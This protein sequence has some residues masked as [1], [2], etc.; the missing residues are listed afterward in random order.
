MAKK[1]GPYVGVTG[2]MSHFEVSEAL[3]MVPQGSARRL[4][5]GVLMSSKTLAGQQNKWPGRY[6]RKEAVADIFVDDPRVLNLIHYSTN[7]PETLSSQLME[8]TELAGPHCDGFQ[9][10]ITWP[11]ISEIKAYWEA[12]PEKFL[13][14]QLKCRA[15]TQVKSMER[16]AELVGA[17][18]PMINAVLIDFR[19][20]RTASK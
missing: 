15:I 4:M 7:H 6:P 14:L 19:R 13:L 12:N 5:A 3:A 1:V 20:T 10:N 16:L 9:L 18:L 8:I 11:P 2:F 17:Y